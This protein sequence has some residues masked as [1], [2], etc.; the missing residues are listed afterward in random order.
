MYLFELDVVG[1]CNKM[2]SALGTCLIIKRV[3]SSIPTYISYLLGKN[4]SLV[5][6]LKR[7]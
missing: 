4:R 1:V 2:G 5:Q 7:T 3:A 6:R